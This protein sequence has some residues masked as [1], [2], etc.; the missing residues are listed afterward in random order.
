MYKR[1]LCFLILMFITLNVF[2]DSRSALNQ[3]TQNILQKFLNADMAGKIE[4]L[5]EVSLNAGSRSQNINAP[6]VYQ[7]AVQFVLDNAKIGKFF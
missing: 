1:I 6:A 2:C 7:N 4:T 3:E 5:Y